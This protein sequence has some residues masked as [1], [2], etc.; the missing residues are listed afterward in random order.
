MYA[1]LTAFRRQLL[2]HRGGRGLWAFIYLGAWEPAAFSVDMSF[3]LLFMVIIAAWARSWAASSARRSSS[4]LPIFLN[5]FL[6]V[7]AGPASASPCST[8]GCPHAELMI[9]GGLIV[10]FLIVRAARPGQALVHG[11]AE[12][13]LWAVPALPVFPALQTTRRQ[14]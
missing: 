7:L 8:A 5:Q 4:V 14:A 12:A 1:K 2:H 3:R 13:A 11:Q 9:F 10:W 6:P